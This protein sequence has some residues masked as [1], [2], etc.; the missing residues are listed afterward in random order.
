MW[1]AKLVV[2]NLAGDAG[3]Q[4]DIATAVN[5]AIVYVLVLIVLEAVEPIHRS[6]A[7]WF[8]ARAVAA[9][10]HRLMEG[11]RRLTGLQKIER[12]TFQDE[13]PVLQDNAYYLPFLFTSLPHGSGRLI[14]LAGMLILLGN[15]HVLIPIALVLSRLSS[16][17]FTGTPDKCNVVHGIEPLSRISGDGLLH[18]GSYGS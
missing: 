10:D 4:P 8:E 14:T 3:G 1:L 7:T 17:T 15:L 18:Q 12:P 5:L 13:L 6:L 9:V 2:D 16:P 11:G